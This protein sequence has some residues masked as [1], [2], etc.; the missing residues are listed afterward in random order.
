MNSQIIG[1]RVAGAI[2]GIMSIVQLVRLLTG[3]QILVAGH[4]L[5]LW[6]NAVAFIIMGGLCIWDVEALLW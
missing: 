3:F 5:P 2:F 4:E 6:P 1:L